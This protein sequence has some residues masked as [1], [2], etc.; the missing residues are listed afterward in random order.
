MK[1][2]ALITIILFLAA[3]N[4]VEAPEPPKPRV[5]S[6][7]V[8]NMG[9][10][11]HALNQPSATWDEKT[12]ELT[13]IMTRDRQRDEIKTPQARV[14]LELT[15]PAERLELKNVGA[16]TLAFENFP[17][18]GDAVMRGGVNQ[19]DA[20]KSLEGSL[21]P[22]EHVLLELDWDGPQQCRGKVVAVVQS[23]SH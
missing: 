20:I 1:T 10:E 15:E 11:D 16:V 23:A 9:D 6:S 21:K 7:I 17:K 14:V 8:V 22:G 13:L 18:H 2:T 19:R 4:R 5:G 12:K 3:C